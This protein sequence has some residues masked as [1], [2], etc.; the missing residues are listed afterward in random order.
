MKLTENRHLAVS[1]T[2][3]PENCFPRVAD[4]WPENAR[5]E[6][7]LPPKTPVSSSDLSCLS[8]A[9]NL[10]RETVQHC[11]ACSGAYCADCIKTFLA[12]HLCPNCHQGVVGSEALIATE[13]TPP[14]GE[15]P[16][17]YYTP[18]EN[19]CDDCHAGHSSVA[20]IHC[21]GP[22]CEVPAGVFESSQAHGQI[23]VTGRDLPTAGGNHVPASKTKGK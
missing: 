16:Q 14:D 8:C 17:G 20:H 13:L 6:V 23:H 19:D 21:G 5:D 15:S 22:P 9:R 4:N 7:T 18:V 11:D 3:W 2:D 10:T 1:I 12:S